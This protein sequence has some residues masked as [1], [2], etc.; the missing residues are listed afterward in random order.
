MK[1]T[2]LV[3]NRL[4]EVNCGLGAEH[5]L[6]F[7]IEHDGKQI[8]CDAGA[9]GLFMEN[10]SA[11]GIDLAACSFAFIS[12][13][14]ND[15]CGGLPALL[16]R[17]T[18]IPVCLHT[19]I[20]GEDYFS[21]RR[22][23]HR[24]LSCDRT[25]FEKHRRRFRY[26][27]GTTEISAGIFAVQCKECKNATPHGNRFLTKKNGKLEIPDDFGHELSLAFVTKKGLVIV[28]PCSHCGALNIIDECRAAT[29]CTKVH[30]YI[31]GLHFVEGAECA[32][33]ATEFACGIA[34]HHP[35]TTVYTGHCT[36]DTA[37]A[38]LEGN[39]HIKSFATGTIIEI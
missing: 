31:G 25:V 18:D 39:P 26:I 4:K 6:S 27:D 12:H 28:S 16:E 20:P 38:L 10:A 36:C 30:A 13:G 17:T 14:H 5:G 19:A 34:A 29:G 1:I 15:H 9:S 22:G 8:L 37:L 3:D 7:H 32:A 24:S 2:V 21:T 33:E 23:T 11:M 35:E